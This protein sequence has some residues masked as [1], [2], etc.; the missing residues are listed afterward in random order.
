[1]FYCNPI[2]I[3]SKFR[4]YNTEAK[5]RQRYSFN[6]CRTE[7]TLAEINVHL[8]FMLFLKTDN[9]RGTNSEYHVDGLVTQRAQASA[10]SRGFY[11]YKC[12]HECYKC[13]NQ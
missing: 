3:H 2:H 10:A 13:E 11:F 12:L 6:L 5:N 9:P 4:T 7:F 1:M 8:H